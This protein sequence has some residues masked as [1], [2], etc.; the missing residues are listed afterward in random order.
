MLS[1]LPFQNC[2]VVIDILPI[3]TWHCGCLDM[4]LLAGCALTCVCWWARNMP[5]VWWIGGIGWRARNMPSCSMN[6]HDTCWFLS[7]KHAFYVWWIDLTFVGCWAWNIS[8]CSVNWLDMCWLLSS[9]HAFMF[10]EFTRR[11]PA[12]PRVSVVE[13]MWI[14]STCVDCWARKQTP[15]CLAKWKVIGQD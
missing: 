5:Y 1:P 2:P 3:L 4:C 9:K 11:V 12:A 15:S 13:L 10:G 7:S 8:S 6:C 14:D